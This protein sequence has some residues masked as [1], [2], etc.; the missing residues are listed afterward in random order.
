MVEISD[1]RFQTG[2]RKRLSSQIVGR[3][4]TTA[5]ST[6]GRRKLDLFQASTGQSKESEGSLNRQRN[7]KQWHS[8]TR[9]TNKSQPI[10]AS[11]L[12]LAEP[13]LCYLLPTRTNRHV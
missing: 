10:Q 3:V 9:Y 6:S 11:L 7:L 1:F 5:D 8:G 13:I 12:W 2:D 4:A